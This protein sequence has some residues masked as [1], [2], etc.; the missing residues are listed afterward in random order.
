MRLIALLLLSVVLIGCEKELSVYS[1]KPL[2]RGGILYKPNSNT[3]LTAKVERYHENGQLK[4]LFTV[5]DGK[6]EG[7]HQVWL[8]NVQLKVEVTYVNGKRDGIQQEWDEGGE[9]DGRSCYKADEK[10]DMSY[11]Q[12]GK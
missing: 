5:I 10:T 11:C 12:N 4:D 7:L 6:L 8:E 1:G 9:P 2:D 3:P